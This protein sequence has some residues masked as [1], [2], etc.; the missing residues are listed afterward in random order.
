MTTRSDCAANKPD[1][2]QEDHRAN[3]G[4]DDCRYKTGAKMNSKSGEKRTPDESAYHA[5]DEI[6][7]DPKPGALHDL[8]SKPSREEADHEHDKEAFIRHV[9]WRSPTGRM[10]AQQ[11]S[12]PAIQQEGGAGAN[13]RDH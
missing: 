3:S 8:T 9:H 5:D 1:D 11:N 2:E 13:R 12:G 7:D 10:L 6:A 4:A